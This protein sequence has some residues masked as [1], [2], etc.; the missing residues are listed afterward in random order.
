MDM[1]LRLFQIVQRKMNKVNTGGSLT[2]KIIV[3]ILF[4]WKGNRKGL[5]LNNI[6]KKCTYTNGVLYF[7]GGKAFSYS[8]NLAG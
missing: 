6:V 2:E 1:Y 8:S 5:N 3:H 4:Y 7:N